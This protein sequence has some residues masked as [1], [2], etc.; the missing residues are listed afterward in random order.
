MRNLTAVRF[1]KA[2]KFIKGNTEAL[3]KAAALDART[4]VR[5][6][7]AAGKGAGAGPPA[8][9]TSGDIRDGDE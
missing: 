1:E 3:P 2:M 5:A 8:F 7:A 9:I 4:K 6:G